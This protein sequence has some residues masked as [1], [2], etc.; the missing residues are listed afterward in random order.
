[1]SAPLAPPHAPPPPIVGTDRIKSARR[2]CYCRRLA[3]RAK[4]RLPSIEAHSG[5]LRASSQPVSYTH[6]T[7]P[8]IC[9]V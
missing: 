8:T 4:A 2:S 5:T 9:S 6:L 3:P 1:M 7:L